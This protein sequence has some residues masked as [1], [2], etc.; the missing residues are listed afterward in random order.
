MHKGST[1]LLRNLILGC[2]TDSGGI[3]NAQ[4][5]LVAQPGLSWCLSCLSLMSTGIIYTVRLGHDPH[6]YLNSIMTFILESLVTEPKFELIISSCS[7]LNTRITGLLVYLYVTLLNCK[8]R[9]ARTTS[10]S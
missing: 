2:I 5:S 7:L 9:A 10:I 6:F 8:L 3:F 4:I 1:S